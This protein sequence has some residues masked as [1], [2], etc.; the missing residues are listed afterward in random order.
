MSAF[1]L[2]QKPIHYYA[3]DVSLQSLTNSINELTE[4]MHGSELLTITG[5]LGT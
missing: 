1:K 4:T 5:L 2:Q 3:L